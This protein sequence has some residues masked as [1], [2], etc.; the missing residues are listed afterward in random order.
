MKKILIVDD[1]EFTRTIH[2]DIVES[3]GFKVI[4]AI[5][6]N[7]ALIKFE[8]QKPDA[9]IIDLLMPDIDGMDVI[10]KIMEK[11]PSTIAII[12]STDKQ[13]HRR[14]DAEELGCKAFLTKPM[15][16]NI[17]FNTLDKYFSENIKRGNNG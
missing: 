11:Y 1:S 4:E 2:R 12:C 5:N 15:D 16:R 3:A 9:I 8:D 10:K 7:D 14:L 13:K 6:G 17:I